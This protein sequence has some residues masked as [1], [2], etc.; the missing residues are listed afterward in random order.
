MLHP[1]PALQAPPEQVG[2]ARRHENAWPYDFLSCCNERLHI[3]VALTYGM[4]EI[5]KSGGITCHSAIPL[6]H[7]CRPLT[8]AVSEFA[9][10]AVPVHPFADAARSFQIAFLRRPHNAAFHLAF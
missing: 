10:A 1:K 7:H 5:A 3:Q 6:H 9:R 4:P 2:I 8:N